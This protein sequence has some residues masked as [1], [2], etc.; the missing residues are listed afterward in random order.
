MIEKNK[1]GKTTI[2]LSVEAIVCL[3]AAIEAIE[4]EY[5]AAPT[6]SALASKWICAQWST[7]HR[8]SPETTEDRTQRI[9]LS[10]RYYLAEHCMDEGIRESQV[11][12]VIREHA[13]RLWAEAGG[14]EARPLGEEDGEVDR[15]RLFFWRP[16]DPSPCF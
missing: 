9:P 13:D 14:D 1:P 5:G 12:E 8:A 4:A 7:Q 11:G 15:E 2:S 6:R 16:E 10:E 3:D